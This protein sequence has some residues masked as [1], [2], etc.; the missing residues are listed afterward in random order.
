MQPSFFLICARTKVAASTCHTRRIFF[1]FFDAV[2]FV[3]VGFL[4]FDVSSP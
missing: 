3:D 2:L 1:R 4:I